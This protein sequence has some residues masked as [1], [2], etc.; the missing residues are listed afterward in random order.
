MGEGGATLRVAAKPEAEAREELDEGTLFNVLDI[1][2]GWAW[3]QVGEDGCVGY[4]PLTAL[5]AQ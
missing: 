2:G 4:L 3:G 5:N 1:T